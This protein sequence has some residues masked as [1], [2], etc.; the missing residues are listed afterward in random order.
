MKV[1]QKAID[2]PNL[3]MKIAET[4]AKLGQLTNAKATLNQ[5][6]TEKPDY[7]PAQ[8]MLKTL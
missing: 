1:A 7:K 2:S 5:L 6:I 4:Q 3:D 8:S